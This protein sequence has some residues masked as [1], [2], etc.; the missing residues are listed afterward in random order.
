MDLRGT[1]TQANTSTSPSATVSVSGI[2]IQANDVVL[3]IIL[4]GGGTGNTFTFPSGFL[5]ISQL[6]NQ[7][8]T[9]DATLGI[10]YKVAGASEP[11]SY[12]VTSSA[13]DY[14]TLHCRVYSGRKTSAPISAASA[15]STNFGGTSPVTYTVPSVA[16]AAGDDVLQ[17][18]GN[19]YYDGSHAFSFSPPAGYGDANLA[20]ATATQYSPTLTVC[21]L[22]N[23]AAGSTTTVGGTIT[24]ATRTDLGYT[25]WTLA[26][27]QAA[28]VPSGTAPAIQQVVDNEGP[29]PP[30]TSLTSLATQFSSKTKAS[31]ALIS[32]LTCACYGQVHND[33]ALMDSQG[34]AFTQ[35]QIITNVTGSQ[36]QST[37]ME[38]YTAL[39]IAG[40]ASTPDTLTSYFTLS[41]DNE[42]Y[43]A[44]FHLEV[45]N[46][47]GIVGSSQ[48]NQLG[49][50]GNGIAPGTGNVNSG[51]P[52]SVSASQLPALMIALAFN[53]SAQ[54]SHPAPTVNTGML[55]QNLWGFQGANL[56]AVSTQA[57][58]TAGS[59][60]AVFNQASS[61]SECMMTMA[62]ILQGV[63]GSPPVFPV[64]RV[65][66]VISTV[67]TPH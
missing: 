27:A 24:A 6:P 30:T 44:H 43:Q 42:D 65:R 28:A 54:G 41:G 14:Q 39:G 23:A 12:T 51:T 2:G 48:N 11:A 19:K 15:G 18:V 31:S 32:F 20:Y 17:I 3:L 59:Y 10:A 46:V 25:A 62:I 36:M 8:V 7:N 49:A 64:R 58:T 16:A 37:Q 1:A 38:L 66:R 22:P 26:L 45:A 33:V 67:H 13:T 40:D 29:N 47:T 50:G 4:G 61:A 52:I 57:I 53:Q 63:P 55:L 21:D 35:Q 56:A 34:N 60:Q 5:P 9:G